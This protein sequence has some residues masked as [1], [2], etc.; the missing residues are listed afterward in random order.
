M[1][2][3]FMIFSLFF[4]DWNV[5]LAKKQGML[6]R[7]VDGTPSNKKIQCVCPRHDLRPCLIFAR[8]GEYTTLRG[9]LINELYLHYSRKWDLVEKVCKRQTLQ[10][11][12]RPIVLPCGAMTL[13]IKTFSITT[14]STK[15]IYEKINV[16]G[17]TQHNRH[18]A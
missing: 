15:G 5:T 7:N 18:S 3:V 10:L 4:Q 1:K 9:E 12:T 14:P 13:S 17:Y 6:T 8:L 16:K 11:F 2:N